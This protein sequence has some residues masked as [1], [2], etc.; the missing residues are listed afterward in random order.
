MGSHTINRLVRYYIE[1]QSGLYSISE[2]RI[3]KAKKII[4]KALDHRLISARNLASIVV[5]IIS[6]SAVVGR[7]TRIMTGQ[8][9]IS[10]NW[11]VIASLN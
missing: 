9:R 1:C 7:L 10:P 5:S 3:E 11:T 6:M 8:C 2:K 4:R